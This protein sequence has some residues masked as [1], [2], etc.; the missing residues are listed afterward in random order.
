MKTNRLLFSFTGLL[1]GLTFSATGPQLGN[2]GTNVFAK[3]GRSENK[4][5]SDTLAA[6]KVTCLSRDGSIMTVLLDGSWVDVR[7]AELFDSTL[8]LRTDEG[9]LS[10][11]AVKNK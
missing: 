6:H 10:L 8:I 9:T 1:F 11:A 5:I 2:I 4:I 3:E 7:E